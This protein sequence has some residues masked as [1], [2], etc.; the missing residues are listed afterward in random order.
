[1]VKGFVY[2]PKRFLL[3]KPCSETR[4]VMVSPPE[5]FSWSSA[6]GSLLDVGYMLVK[7]HCGIRSVLL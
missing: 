4:M 3:F 7:V 5:N 6:A 2:A 1:M